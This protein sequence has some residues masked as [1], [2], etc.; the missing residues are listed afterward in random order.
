MGKYR[1]LND[2]L[3]SKQAREVSMTFAEV[4]AVIGRSL[5]SSAFT[6]PAWWANDPTPNRQS[7][8][9]MSVGYRTESVDLRRRTVVFRR[10][11]GDAAAVGDG[12]LAKTAAPYRGD[13]EPSRGPRAFIGCMQGTVRIAEGFDLTTP[14]DPEW[15]APDLDARA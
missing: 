1:P 11:D 13:A 14:A 8:A 4:E 10:H 5:P 3:L 2:F 15:G 7:E 12:G 9:W 6:Y